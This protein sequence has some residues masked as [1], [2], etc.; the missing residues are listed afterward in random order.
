SLLKKAGV[1]IEIADFIGHTEGEAAVEL[2]CG[3]GELMEAMRPWNPDIAFIGMDMNPHLLE[4]AEGKFPKEESVRRF[5]NFAF[6]EKPGV[7]IRMN[8]MY[9]SFMLEGGAVSLILDDIRY[10]NSTRTALKESRMVPTLFT[11][12]FPSPS[13]HLE[14]EHEW[15]NPHD[16]VVVRKAIDTMYISA[17][18][19]AADMMPSG[20]KLVLGE[21]LSAG[22][23]NI[24][25][26]FERMNESFCGG[27][28][29]VEATRNLSRDRIRGYQEL[30]A[31][32]ENDFS[33]VKPSF[34]EGE[35]FVLV[36]LERK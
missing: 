35:Y 26:V 5:A 23:D 30:Y 21:A 9:R 7:G 22:S 10:M 36:K 12:V 4:A 19:K 34:N 27:C 24:V 28:Y 32:S 25:R 20:G 11:L 17:M 2:G 14:L 31:K 16:E 29:R 8:P 18:K 33:R 3:S 15:Y 1:Y 13:S 6:D